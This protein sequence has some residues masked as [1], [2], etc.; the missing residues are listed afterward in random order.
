MSNTYFVVSDT[1]EYICWYDEGKYFRKMLSMFVNGCERP[2]QI[3]G[4]DTM[5]GRFIKNSPEHTRLIARRCAKCE[6]MYL[7]PADI[8]ESVCP[9]CQRK[10]MEKEEGS[11][12]EE[13]INTAKSVLAFFEK[14]GKFPDPFVDFKEIEEL[15]PSVRDRDFS[16][17]LES[18]CSDIEGVDKDSLDDLFGMWYE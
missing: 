2:P 7:L 12:K 9:C 11:S 4:I 1:G 3:V 10:N 5:A 13:F 14:H 18:V 15:E 6:E 16:E 8:D 17:M